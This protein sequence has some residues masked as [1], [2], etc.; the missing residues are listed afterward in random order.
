LL[1]HQSGGS[2]RSGKKNNGTKKQPGVNKKSRGE[3]L[4]VISKRAP[5]GSTCSAP[6]R[7]NKSPRVDELRI[8]RLQED[9]TKCEQ[10]ADGLL[11]LEPYFHLAQ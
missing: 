6:S 8:V 4:S 11:E 5:A 1:L 2:K 7:H 3:R 10:F 9:G